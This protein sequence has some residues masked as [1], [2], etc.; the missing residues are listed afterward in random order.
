[1]GSLQWEVTWKLMNSF[2][3]EMDKVKHIRIWE[4]HVIIKKH[5]SLLRRYFKTDLRTSR[6]IPF[7][8]VCLKMTMFIFRLHNDTFKNSIDT[9][10]LE[11]TILWHVDLLLGN[12]H[13]ISNYTTTV[14]RQWPVNSDRGKVFSVWSVP[15]CY[16]QK[17]GVELLHFSRCE[18]LLIEVGSWGR[19]QFGNP[20][21]K[22][23]VRRW[24]SLSSNG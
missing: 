19:G 18:L 9:T 23:T 7:S 4:Y 16:T 6:N 8:A 10:E 21:R 15:K 20:Q 24:K 1:M 17:L 12:D 22:G 5:E 3:V 14:T 11:N 13:E 2:K